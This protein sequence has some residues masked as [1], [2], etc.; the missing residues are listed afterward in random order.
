M[1]AASASPAE[2][3]LKKFESS[4]QRAIRKAERSG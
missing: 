3:V 2:E 4:V 1:R